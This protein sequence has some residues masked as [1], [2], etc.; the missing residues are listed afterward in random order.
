MILLAAMVAA[1]LPPTQYCFLCGWSAA[2]TT[3]RAATSG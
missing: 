3:P 1:V 2:K